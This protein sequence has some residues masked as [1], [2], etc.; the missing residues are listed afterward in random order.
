MHSLGRNHCWIGVKA[1][2]QSL[3][4]NIDIAQ[5]GGFVVSTKAA[6]Q[7]SLMVEDNIITTQTYHKTQFTMLSR[8]KLME[9][10]S[11]SGVKG[12][13]YTKYSPYFFLKAADLEW[14]NLS[15]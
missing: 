8:E 5:K 13:V 2:A 15:S 10:K 3:C 14:L 1:S 4:R 9:E 11:F 7:S 12:N 6:R